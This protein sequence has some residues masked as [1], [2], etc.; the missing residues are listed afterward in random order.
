MVHVYD[1]ELEHP[2]KAA[3]AWLPSRPASAVNDHIWWSASNSSVF[4][5]AGDDGDLVIN[6]GMAY[7][8]PRHRERLEQAVGRPL[9]V[10]A[11]IL[12][13][14]HPDHIGGW[15]AFAGPETRTIA[16]ARLPETIAERR[17]V[18]P[19]LGLRPTAELF[20]RRALAEETDASGDDRPRWD[21]PDQEVTTFVEDRLELE[22]GG[23]RYELFSVPGGETLDG[24]AVWLEAERTMW[25][26]NLL[27]ALYGALPHLATI[28]GDRPR[29]ATLFARSVQRV[30]DHEPEVLLTGHGGPI[31]GAARI[32]AELGR[33]VE[34]VQW[35]HD[36]TIAGMNAGKDLYELM[37]TIELPAG[38]RTEPGRGPVSWYV[39]A[40]WEEYVGWFRG[41]SLTELYPV[42]QRRI[43]PRLV[44][45]AGGADVLVG[46]AA[47]SLAA[48]EPV[49]ALHYLDI[50]LG[51]E[52][53]HQGA[54][55]V[56]LEAME[57]LLERSQGWAYD[58]ARLLEL[59]IA[60]AGRG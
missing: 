52:P 6:C 1:T 36:E 57:E 18:A 40:V 58:E 33:I 22:V 24:L 38:L 48:G 27:G 13:Q 31:R 56:R 30:L 14:S 59:E 11:I 4:L 50:V 43:W 51:V 47:A 44:E 16:Q 45:L 60:K 10:R 39:R 55:T 32:A 49:E 34:A 3:T 37:A 12:T 2:L 19:Y 53:E 46:E 25:T 17:A 21:L 7:Q 8:G 28:R 26:G 9:D 29:S 42:P 35:I 54:A 15:Y 5:V 20:V 41:E 23:R